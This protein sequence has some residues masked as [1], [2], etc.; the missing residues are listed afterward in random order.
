[1]FNKDKIDQYKII[2][3][4]QINRFE[5]IRFTG[6]VIFGII[7]ILIFWSGARAVES[8]YQ[9]QKQITAINEQNNIIRLQNNDIKLQ[10]E[11]YRSN[12]YIELQARQNLGLA[13]PGETE[14]IVPSNIALKYVVKVNNT[15]ST[16]SSSN[17]QSITKN[18]SDWLNFF[19]HK[20]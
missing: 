16:N 17:S 7:V 2:V 14:L 10:N 20:A 18:F 11:Y 1:M 13:Y 19:F 12:Q 8:N 15:Y 3:I 6:Q 5:D 9:L 4:N